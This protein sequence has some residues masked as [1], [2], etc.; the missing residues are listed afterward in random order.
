M[1]TGKV[2]QDPRLVLIGVIVLAMA[3][4]EGAANDAGTL[5]QRTARINVGLMRPG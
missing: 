3:L 2:W 4:A 5:T 1:R